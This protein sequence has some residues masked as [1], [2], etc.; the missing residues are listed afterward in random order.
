MARA[1]AA[2]HERAR[3]VPAPR[4]QGSTRVLE[5]NSEI[6]AWRFAWLYQSEATVM[7]PDTA[8]DDTRKGMACQLKTPDEQG[9]IK[10]VDNAQK[11]FGC[12]LQ[13]HVRA[14]AT[15]ERFG[16]DLL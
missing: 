15:P 12:G 9:Q 13:H 16:K 14:A 11:P 6:G 4:A 3:A 7:H 10:V 5:A 1:G 2:S 8:G